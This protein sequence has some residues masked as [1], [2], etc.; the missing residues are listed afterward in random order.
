MYSSHT[1]RC[2]LNNLPFVDSFHYYKTIWSLCRNQ[3]AS[4]LRRRIHFNRRSSR[5]VYLIG[6]GNGR[7][8]GMLVAFEK[9]NQLSKHSPQAT[10][11]LQIT[12]SA[13]GM[14]SKALTPLLLEVLHFGEVLTWQTGTYSVNYSRPVTTARM[15]AMAIT[16]MWHKSP[17]AH[18]S[19]NALNILLG[20]V[21]SQRYR[22]SSVV[23]L[24]PYCHISLN[25]CP[26]SRGARLFDL[27]ILFSWLR[28]L[29]A[30]W[31]C[32]HLQRCCDN[33]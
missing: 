33:T 8:W 24:Q 5:V 14:T 26:P 31:I 10:I 1:A 28:C 29:G 15:Q 19:T 11:P 2:K 17:P 6:K 16:G 7:P 12:L 13:F 27:R 22:Y 30:S 20:L 25:I 4:I 3:T 18:R 23:F 21:K 32:C 9:P